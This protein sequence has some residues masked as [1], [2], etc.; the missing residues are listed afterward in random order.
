MVL[1]PR[2][3]GRLTP[4]DDGVPKV[5]LRVVGIEVAEIEFPTA[6]S[7]LA[8][9]TVLVANVLAIGPA[10]VA[11]ARLRPASLLRSE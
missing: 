1:P 9:G 10:V 8:A 2:P 3:S 11:A 6:S 5:A 7:P 4:C